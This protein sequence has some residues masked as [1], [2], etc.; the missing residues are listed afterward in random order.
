MPKTPNNTSEKIQESLAA[1]AVQ[2]LELG[3]KMKNLRL[4]HMSYLYSPHLKY[5]K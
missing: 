4:I 2:D 1:T 3:G 5:F